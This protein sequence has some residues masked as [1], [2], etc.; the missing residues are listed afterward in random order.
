MSC[1]V[2]VK[3]LGLNFENS[4]Q[5]KFQF[6]FDI[7]EVTKAWSVTPKHEPS[8]YDALP[9]PS[10]VFF[11]HKLIHFYDCTCDNECDNCIITH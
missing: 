6:T 1:N 3:N 11:N 9:Q 10:H 2:C 7:N 4:Q 8:L 5:G